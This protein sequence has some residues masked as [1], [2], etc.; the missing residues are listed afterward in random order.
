MGGETPGGLRGP[1]QPA[2]RGSQGEGRCSAVALRAM[3]GLS[4]AQEERPM[5]LVI[6]DYNWSTW[7]LR[8][9][10][11]LK[12]C[13]APFSERMI[14]LNRDDTNAEIL[15]HSPSGLVPA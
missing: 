15:K 13:G 9:W 7:S 14:H 1:D 4:H 2:G 8:P 11:V 10:L 6:G 5:E 3:R 12:R